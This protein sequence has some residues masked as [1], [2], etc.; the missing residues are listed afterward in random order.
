MHPNPILLVRTELLS[1]GVLSVRA[2]SERD[3][4]S[5]HTL[6][7]R[8]S[9]VAIEISLFIGRCVSIQSGCC[10]W[11]VWSGGVW[12]G[13]RS[14]NNASIVEGPLVLPWRLF[15]V[16]FPKCE[17]DDML[18]AH[19][20]HDVQ[21]GVHVIRLLLALAFSIWYTG[22]CSR[23]SMMRMSKKKWMRLIPGRDSTRFR[24]KKCHSGNFIFTIC[25]HPGISTR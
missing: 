9:F 11:V 10:I 25:K 7:T 13:S 8:I 24:V 12:S 22:C 18:M 2:I 19:E 21:R 5:Y 15:L 1:T 16:C 17:D 6:F 14:G 4:G 20:K 3:P 23:R